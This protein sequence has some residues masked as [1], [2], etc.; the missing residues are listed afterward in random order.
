MIA[1]ASTSPDANTTIVAT[2]GT[3]TI[4]GT[5][6]TLTG[7]V[8]LQGLANAINGTSNSPVT[9]SVVQTDANKFR[10]VLTANASGTANAFTVTNGLSGGAGVTFTDTD[11]DGITGNSDADNAVKA[12]NADV[13]V[14]NVEIISASNTLTS[15]IPG[16]T[17]TVFKKDPA[18]T[19]GVDVSE[20][21]SA[22]QSNLSSFVSAYNNL[23]SFT[24]SQWK[25]AAGG[26]GTAIG[27]DPLVRGLATALRSTMT[28]AYSNSGALGYLSQLGVEFTQSGTLQLNQSVFQAAVANGTADA[29]KLLVGTDD[30]PGAFATLDATLSGYTQSGGLLSTSQQLLTTQIGNLGTQISNMQ[31][32]LSQQR[33][34]LTQ[35]FTA[36]DL[37]MSQLQSQSSA[38]S[39]VAS[40]LSSSASSSSSS[41]SG[42]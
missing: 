35:E 11:G 38:L 17:L 26:D 40:S 28:A 8:T 19:V 25:A 29:E 18:T 27:R 5:P 33:T 21:S 23:V 7:P 9:A 36:A 4:G 6:V 2:S 41:S 34:T 42:G 16:A 31:A 15:A 1:S 13:L 12:T 37:A 3:L 32:R 22:L 30:A 20:D 10:L 24:N 14:N 39:G